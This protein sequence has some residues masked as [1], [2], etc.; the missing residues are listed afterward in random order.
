MLSL[1]KY[2][3]GNP[4]P[5]AKIIG[6]PL[7]NKLIYLYNIENPEKI[8]TEIKIEEGKMQPIPYMMDGIHKLV[9]ILYVSARQ[10]AGKSTYIANYIKEYH[11]IYPNNPIYLFSAKIEDGKLVDDAYDEKEFPYLNVM[12]TDESLITQPLE[13]KEFNNSLVIFD[14]ID[15]LTDKK[16]LEKIVDFRKS[17]MT[18][19]RDK[20]IFVIVT[21]HVMCDGEKTKVFLN[22]HNQGTFFKGCNPSQIKRYLKLYSG[23]EDHNMQKK[24]TE[25]PSRWITVNQTFPAYIIYEKGIFLL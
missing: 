1:K 9:D 3:E 2:K 21:S 19:G 11:K 18:I 25:L 16:V 6:G 4:R 14:D 10:G 13:P 5:I 12:V 24:I 20:G 8:D 15:Q 23:V 22:E 7:D 17:I